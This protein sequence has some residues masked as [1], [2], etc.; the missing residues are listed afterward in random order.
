MD[1]AEASRGSS[2]SHLAEQ[3][4]GLALGVSDPDR[5]S[6][7]SAPVHLA[8]YGGKSLRCHNIFALIWI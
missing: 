4:V 2:S 1:F 8:H 3:N 5:C 7:S 6:G